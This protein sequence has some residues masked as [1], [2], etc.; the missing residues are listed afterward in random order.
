MLLE[1][2]QHSTADCQS[3]SGSI[4]AGRHHATAEGRGHGNIGIFSR[5]N[6]PLQHVTCLPQHMQP[7]L[8]LLLLP[9]L[10]I[11]CCECHMLW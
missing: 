10:S 5:L 6:A 11:A 9:P 3:G 2:L 8:L 7:V 4:T 1:Q